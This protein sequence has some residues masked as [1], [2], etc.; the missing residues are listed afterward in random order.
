MSPSGKSVVRANAGRSATEQGTRSLRDVA[1]LAGV[2]EATASRALRD[3]R[4]VGFEL[5]ERVLL[6]AK[7]LNFTPNPHARALASATDASVGIVVHDI[8]DPYFSEIVRGALE[9]AAQSGR[10]LLICNT[11]RD[12]QRELAYIR[13]FRAQRVEALLL[14]G[15]GDGEAGTRI[16]V[17]I[18]EFE[19][20]GGR[21]VLMGRYQTARNA[22]MADNIGG[23]RQMADHL[24]E[25]GHRRI[26]VIAGPGGLT[27]SRLSGF[28]G[29]L[30]ALGVE[31]PAERVRVGEFT[32]DGGKTAAVELLDSARD[33]TA[34]FALS[35]VMA[36]GVLAA[37]RERGIKVPGDISV[38]GFDDI[39]MAQDLQPPLTTVSVP[40]VDMGRR[41]FAVALS[42]RGDEAPR[43]KRLPTALV[44][45][46]STAPP[47]A[48][49][50]RSSSAG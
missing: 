23:A 25:L 16:E 27:G 47:R 14:A 48:A 9:G 30:E 15:S 5:R 44:V 20:G 11:Y 17:E 49:R 12:P 4:N 35:D 28:L 36:I 31:L 42:R 46:E 22:I 29:R 33:L 18:R 1:E 38:G 45:R 40:M 24:V 21:A 50:R 32:R 39:P 37:L 3:T 34:I 13:H 26:A 41:A 10:M 19:R 8:S 43:F 7:K 2:S 6:A